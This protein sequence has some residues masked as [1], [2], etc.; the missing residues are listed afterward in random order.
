MDLVFVTFWDSVACWRAWVWSWVFFL[1]D[2][3]WILRCLWV[4]RA[5]FAFVFG[6]L[7]LV[8]GCCFASLLGSCF[9]EAGPLEG[10][11]FEAC[12]CFLGLLVSLRLCAE[13]VGVFWGG[14]A[15]WRGLF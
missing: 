6:S 3:I 4:E 9:G 1:V 8:N 7:L 5:S 10:F 14:W 2:L 15:F 12:F 11:G 13:V